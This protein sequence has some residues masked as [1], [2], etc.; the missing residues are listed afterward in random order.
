MMVTVTLA[1]LKTAADIRKHKTHEGHS[2]SCPCLG[3]CYRCLWV[4]A[5]GKQPKKK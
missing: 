5:T 3:G 4:N 2:Q 1:G